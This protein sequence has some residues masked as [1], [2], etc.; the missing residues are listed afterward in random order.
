MPTEFTDPKG[1]IRKHY[2]Y[3]DMMTP[4]DKLKSLPEAASYL[5]P[6]MSFDRLD[7]PASE[8]SDNEA[9]KRLHEARAKL[10][11]LINK[12][13]NAPPDTTRFTTP[14]PAHVHIGKY[15]FY[16]QL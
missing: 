9:V 16:A 14:A 12:S 15:S 7:A 6:G 5:K 3:A 10:F 1:R 2:R 4:Y 11:Q 13:N 8:C